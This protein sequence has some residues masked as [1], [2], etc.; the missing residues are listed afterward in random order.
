MDLHEL[1]ADHQRN[2]PVGRRIIEALQREIGG[3]IEKHKVTLGVPLEGRVKTWDS[4]KEKI[5]RKSITIEKISELN[6]FIGIRIIVL[7][8]ND[9]EV[10]RNFLIKDLNILQ[11]D[12]LTEKL[13]N[14][15]FGYLSEHFLASIPKSWLQVPSYS[16]FGDLRVEIQL[17]TLAQH[18]WAVASHQLQYKREESVPA[19]VKRTISRISALLET[20]DLEFIRILE[21]RNEYLSVID[22]DTHD[23]PLNVDILLLIMRRNFPA[24]NEKP[25]EQLDNLLIELGMINISTEQTLQAVIDKHLPFVL[26]READAMNDIRQGGRRF[27]TDP[28]RV[29]QGVFYAFSGLLRVLMKNEVGAEKFELIRLKAGTLGSS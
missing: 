7:F 22:T 10:V 19:P 27:H 28:E 8:H 12:N 17:R 16:D 1:Q 29:S 14:N 21:Q 15:Q 24:A 26:E 13:E 3:L 9:L 25:P 5:D 18:I 11:S 6:D 20:I 2:V 23:R 4:I